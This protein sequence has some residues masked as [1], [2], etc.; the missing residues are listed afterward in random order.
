[1]NDT[2]LLLTGVMVF[3]LMFIAVI[4]T[5][6]EFRRIEKKEKNRLAKAKRVSGDA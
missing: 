2:V 4:L 3:G 5:V 6:V 1:M